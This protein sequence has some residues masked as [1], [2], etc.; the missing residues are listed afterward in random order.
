MTIKNNSEIDLRL[1]MF[2]ASDQAKII[3]REN[4]ILKKGESKTYER[5]SYV[6]HVWKSQFFDASI[7]WTE[8]LWT[9]IEFSGSEDN[10]TIKG[11]DKPPVTIRNEANQQLKIC[12]YNADDKV[13]AIPLD[14][15]TLSPGTQT[16]WKKAPQEF[17]IKAF[18]PALLDNPVLTQSNVQ[19]M[20]TITI[21]GG[22]Q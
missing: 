14:C 2:N 4:W 21:K 13:Q 6:F 5:N 9:D 11:S 8:P 19:D 16:T 3:A 17:L 15:W 12:I 7:Q 22:P 18:K 10:L 20:S 1:H